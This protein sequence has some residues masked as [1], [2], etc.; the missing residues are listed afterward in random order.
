MDYLIVLDYMIAYKWNQSDVERCGSTM[1]LT[2]THERST[3]GDDVF[4]ALVWLAFNCPSVYHIDFT[5]ILVDWYKGHRAAIGQYCG[6][7][8][9]VISR[10]KA[11]KKHSILH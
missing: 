1:Q 3:L 11:V 2:K 8:S 10:L 6:Q 5:P 4:P 7:E 9:R